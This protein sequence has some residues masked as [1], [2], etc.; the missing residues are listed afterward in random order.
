MRRECFDYLNKHLSLSTLQKSESDGE[1]IMAL[2]NELYSELEDFD[3]C[4]G[5]DYHR[6]ND[7]IEQLEERIKKLQN[8]SAE[9][10]VRRGLLE[11]V[12]PF[13]I[14]SNAGFDDQLYELAEATCS[15]DEDWRNQA[16]MLEGIHQNWPTRQ[17]REI[18][19]KLGDRAKYLE[20]RHTQMKYGDDY[21]DLATFYWDEGNREQALAIA[22]EGMK[23]GEG[24]MDG[25]RSFLSDRAIE[26]GN[27]EKY[28][29]LQF[30]QATQYLSLDT[31][32]SFKNICSV[33]EWS[34]FE[35]KIVELLDKP[36]SRGYLKI[37]MHREE[38]EEVLAILLK[39][40]YP[41]NGG[42]S[43]DELTV[44][45]ELEQRFPEQILTYYLSGLRNLNSNASRNE[46]ANRTE[47]VVKVRRML[48][49]VIKDESRWKFFAGK[50]KGDNI[51]RP[52][53][54]EEFGKVIAGWGEL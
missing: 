48:V 11:E 21:H 12:M 8:S 43:G 5:G 25:L 45:K 40:I 14:S 53:F 22:E 4:G 32:N 1:I 39:R 44:A 34:A 51:R 46:Y 36:S 41:V 31:Y 52:A 49:D 13:I 37:R 30:E 26:D 54:Q 50:I 18:Y 3:E 19:Q 15:S 24:R 16:Q 9:E 35:P 2:W 29:A 6:E 47:V 33:E 42:E 28:L 7:L 20:L 27:R 17:A 38:Y 23:K 10:K